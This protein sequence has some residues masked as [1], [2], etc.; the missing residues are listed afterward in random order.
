MDK[1]NI[2]VDAILYASMS[3]QVLSVAVYNHYKRIYYESLQKRLVMI[4]SLFL[5]SFCGRVHLHLFVSLRFHV[6]VTR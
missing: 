3:M 5:Y 2:S 4:V 1:L 6:F